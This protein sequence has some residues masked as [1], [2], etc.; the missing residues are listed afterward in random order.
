MNATN[1][2]QS[3]EQAKRLLRQVIISESGRK[4]MGKFFVEDV[5]GFLNGIGRVAPLAANAD[6]E[7]PH[8][9]PTDTCPSCTPGES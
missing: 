7:C 1:E 2:S 3:L 5:Q 6:R 8:G 4:A 9:V